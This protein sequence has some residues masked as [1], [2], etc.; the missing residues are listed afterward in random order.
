MYVFRSSIG[1]VFGMFVSRES[2][3]RL[4]KSFGRNLEDTALE[5]CR[6]CVK[7]CGCL[8]YAFVG[9]LAYSDN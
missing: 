7:R 9:G 2:E 4:V 1:D 6:G 5:S 3:A 8:G